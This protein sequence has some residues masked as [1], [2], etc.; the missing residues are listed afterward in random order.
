MKKFIISFLISSIIS[1]FYFTNLAQAS[2]KN[3]PN[4][5]NLLK[6]GDECQTQIVNLHPTQQEIGIYQVNF[7]KTLLQIIEAGKSQKY[8]NLDQYLEKKV[9]PVI[10]GDNNILY[11]IDK[12]HTL[13]AIWEYF[14][15]NREQ[16]VYIKV[17]DNWSQENNFWQKMEKNNYVYLGG[18]NKKIHPQQLPDEIGK[19]INNN[20]RSAVGLAA[21]WTYLQQPKGEAK[22]FY[23]F[24]WGDCLQKLGFILPPE[25][26]RDEIY[27]TAAFL[28]D[29]NNQD[30]FSTVCNLEPPQEV[31]VEDII[32]DLETSDT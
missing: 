29:Q 1:V 24:K 19:L 18:E 6:V 17:I 13:R 31:S 15:Y 21:K 7:T 25:I 22:Y 23:Q 14:N 9:I 32:I 5:I 2:S 10:I 11:M 3:C 26:Q 16:K 8:K 30:K 20:Y 28:H 12:H 4:N 27:A